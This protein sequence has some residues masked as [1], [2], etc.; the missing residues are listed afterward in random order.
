MN[1]GT[2]IAHQIGAVVGAAAVAMG[3]REIVIRFDRDQLD[4]PK[5][6]RLGETACRD[7]TGEPVNETPVVFTPPRLVASNGE[8]R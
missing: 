6:L 4:R 5:R 1:L 3:V 8:S 2:A 7:T